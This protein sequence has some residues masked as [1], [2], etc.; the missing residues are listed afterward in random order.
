MQMLARSRQSHAPAKENKPSVATATAKPVATTATTTTTMKPVAAA[1]KEEAEEKRGILKS[2]ASRSDGAAPASAAAFHPISLSRVFSPA[3]SPSAG[4][5][6]RKLQQQQQQQQQREK[7]TVAPQSPSP[8]HKVRRVSFAYPIAE[9]SDGTPATKALQR[10]VPLRRSFKRKGRYC[11]KGAPP[12][13]V[14]TAEDQIGNLESSTDEKWMEAA[15]RQPDATKMDASDEAVASTQS[16][17]A[18]ETPEAATEADDGNAVIASAASVKWPGG[19]AVERVGRFTVCRSEQLNM[20]TEVAPRVSES[21]GQDTVFTDEH[22][23]STESTPQTTADQ[24]LTDRVTELSAHLRELP[25]RA[26]TLSDSDL[27][28]LQRRLYEAIGTVTGVIESRWSS[29]G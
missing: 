8:P 20:S 22:P 29:T 24:L 25:T 23:T 15:H 6:K 4:I 10:C 27:F 18:T 2:P 21:G 7:T 13:D 26:A 16:V 9:T 5:L 11:S 19:A 3:A 1:M 12:S 14:A 17:V 28:E